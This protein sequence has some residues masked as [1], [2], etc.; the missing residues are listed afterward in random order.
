MPVMTTFEDAIL[1]SEAIAD[2]LHCS[3]EVARDIMRMED[4]PLLQAGVKKLLRVRR[5]DFEKWLDT[6]VVRRP[7]TAT[8]K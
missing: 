4:F 1:D 5:V 3:R 8:P 2:Y 7:G 6:R